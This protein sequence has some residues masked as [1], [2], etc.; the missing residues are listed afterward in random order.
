MDANFLAFALGNVDEF[1]RNSHSRGLLKQGAD[2]A[3]QGAAGNVGA[4]E[5]VLYDGIIGAANF[6]RALPRPDMEA[7][8]AVESAFKNYFSQQL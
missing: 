5:S 3:T 1:R 6:E 4:S 2:T 8:F 7:G